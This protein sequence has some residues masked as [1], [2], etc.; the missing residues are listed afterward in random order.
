M[1]FEAQAAGSLLAQMLGPS[2]GGA[3]PPLSM[4]SRFEQM[5]QALG[6]RSDWRGRIGQRVLP[7]DVD[8]IDDPTAQQFQGQDLIGSYQVDQEGVR[9]QKVAIVQEG[10]LKAVADVA[11]A[12]AGFRSTPTATAASTF[13]ADARPMM[14]NLFFTASNG[15]SPADL[16]KKFLDACKQNGQSLGL[17]VREM[18][19]PVIASSSQDELSDSLATL[20]TGAPNGDR[21]PL[22]VYRVNVDDGHEELVR[23][24]DFAGLTA[25]NLRKLLGD[26]QRQ[27]G[28]HLC[29]E[30]GCG[31]RRAPRWARSAARRRR[32]Q[33]RHRAVAAVRGGR[34][35]R[36]PRGATAA[37]RWCLLR[38]CNKARFPHRQS[39]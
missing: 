32:A 18:D 35:A 27:H 9:A 6:G 39:F 8:L 5:M 31:D 22:L 14:S 13:L 34:S 28:L 1:L 2:V 33:R 25:R 21:M 11:P 26:R 12:R 4:N 15:E 3:R 29:A 20:A 16:R 30:P 37:C 23:G 10:L 36:A 24:A 19:N 17:I 38:R 7:A